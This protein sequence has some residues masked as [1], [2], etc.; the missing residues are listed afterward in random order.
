MGY[1]RCHLRATEHTASEAAA[2][3]DTLLHSLGYCT[4]RLAEL[5][6]MRSRGLSVMAPVLCKRNRS[7]CSICQAP[8]VAVVYMQEGWGQLCTV[9]TCYYL[10]K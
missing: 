2:C 6:V 5:S 7:G 8:A 3:G 9:V 1:P 4:A 10:M